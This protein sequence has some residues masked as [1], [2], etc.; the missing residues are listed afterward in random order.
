MET[1]ASKL[2]LCVCSVNDLRSF[3]VAEL[4]SIASLFN[5]QYSFPYGQPDESRPYMIIQLAGDSEAKLL[6]TRLVSVKHIW[7]LWAEG[8]TY[9]AVHE[10]AKSKKAKELWS[11]YAQD[12]DCTWK[13]T[14][15][16]HNR[17]IPLS[18][19]IKT[20]NSFSYMA[21]L[22]DIDLKKPQLEVGVFEEYEFDGTRGGRLVAMREKMGLADLKGKKK[23]RD[24]EVWDEDNSKLRGVWVGRKISDCQRSL[25][26]YFDLKKRKYIGTTSMEAEA[27]LLMA[28]QA[29][30]AP[31]KWIYDPFAGTGSM[32]LTAAGFGAMTFGSDIDGRQMRGKKTNIRDSAAQYGVTDRIVDCASFDM[33]QHPFRTGELFDAIVTDPPYGV[34]AGAKRSGREEGARQVLP[35]VV[36]G[37]EKEGYHHQFD[38]YVPPSVGWPMEE[39][40]VGLITYSLYLLKPGGRLVFFLPTNESEYSDID[41]PEVPGLK[42]I[43]NTSQSFGKWARRL[44]TMEKLPKGS[45]Q[46]VEGLDRGI[47]REG[48]TSLWTEGER[49][50]R[51]EK[52]PGHADFRER[53]Y[54]GF[55]ST[56]R[57][58]QEEL[59]SLS[60][61]DAKE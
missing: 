37:R 51:E 19:Q 31:G 5:I 18:I 17:T 49:K 7:E 44:I 60:I 52:K 1:T 3:R 41:V 27:S 26:D 6:A 36:P 20:I 48:M 56:K 38:D 57:Q 10:Q 30:A 8:T 29:Q 43:S 53:Y 54:E 45:E 58:V 61:R 35:T 12:R 33:N 40:I 32:L 55:G 42:L 50:R 14:V 22:G 28:N 34:R 25:I 11:P 13:F 59:A 15:A 21:F 23:E 24:E 39:V 46:V 4:D 2:Y 47:E 9:E 16:G